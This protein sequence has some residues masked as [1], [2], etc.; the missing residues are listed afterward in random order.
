MRRLTVHWYAG[1]SA[2]V[3]DERWA[4]F[5]RDVADWHGYD[6]QTHSLHMGGEDFAV[7]LS[8]FPAR[9]SVSAAPANLVLHHPA[10]NPDE[11]LIEPPPAI[12][13]AGGK[14]LTPAITEIRRQGKLPEK[15]IM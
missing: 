9:L 5:T 8:I 13:R 15:D 12:L 6:T 14:S 11:A 1:P 7:Y 10:F 2:L 3:N 4:A